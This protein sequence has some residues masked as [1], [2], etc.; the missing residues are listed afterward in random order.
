VQGSPTDTCLQDFGYPEPFHIFVFFLSW[1]G[2]SNLGG[3]VEC[4]FMTEEKKV[5]CLHQPGQ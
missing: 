2:V 1:E 5:T 4:D 3:V